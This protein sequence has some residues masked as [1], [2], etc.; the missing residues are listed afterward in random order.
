MKKNTMTKESRKVS[1][2]TRDAVVR[3]AEGIAVLKQKSTEFAQKTGETW[4]KSKPQQQKAKEELKKAA[5][6][7]V[8]FGKEVRDGLKEGFAEVQ[9]RNHKGA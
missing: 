5:H 3:L 1:Q 8:E 2:A 4:E 6:E 9:K 7:V